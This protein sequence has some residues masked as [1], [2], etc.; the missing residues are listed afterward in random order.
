MAEQPVSRKRILIAFWGTIALWIVY[1]F[2]LFWLFGKYPLNPQIAFSIAIG[3]LLLLRGSILLIN[4]APKLFG[5][6]RVS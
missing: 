3:G 6:N 2:Y 5:K 1:G 4:A